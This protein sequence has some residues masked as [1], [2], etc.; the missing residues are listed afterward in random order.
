MKIHV[1]FAIALTLSSVTST[2]AS[3]AY[4]ENVSKFGW[5]LLN[6][7]MAIVPHPLPNP[8]SPAAATII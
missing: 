1:L 8:S 3:P 7:F 4:D 6:F 5:T 2:I